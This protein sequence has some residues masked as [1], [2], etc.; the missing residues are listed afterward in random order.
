MPCETI[1]LPDGSAVIACR[2]RTRA[3]RCDIRGCRRSHVALC[4]H[5]L[6]GYQDGRTCN[7]RLCDL[8]RKRTGPDTDLCP[9]HV[10]AARAEKR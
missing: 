3:A 6:E 1:R 9:Y 8:H 10:A 4:D 7:V 5:V 2:G